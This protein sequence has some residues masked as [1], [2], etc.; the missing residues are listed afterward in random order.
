MVQRLAKDKAVSVLHRLLPQHP[1]LVVIGADTTVV[2]PRGRV[3][4]KP[5]DAS[6]ARRMLSELSG[7]LHTVLTGYCLC[8]ASAGKIR[9]IERVVNSKVR[10][11]KLS[12]DIIRQYI[13]TGEPMDKAGAYAAQG[14]G[15][16]LI[17]E[18]RGSYTNV[19][20]L[21]MAELLSD[22]RKIGGTEPRLHRE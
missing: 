10:I 1:E 9:M 22:L 12:Q 4:G 8:I 11:A 18:I 19:V 13:D 17:E 16:L 7:R 6:E 5:R 21:P 20:G 3:L 14:I 15:M 2:S